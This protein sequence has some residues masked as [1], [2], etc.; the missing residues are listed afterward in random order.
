MFGAAMDFGGLN[1]K[2]LLFEMTGLKEK[3]SQVTGIHTDVENF[4]R[5]G[6]PLIHSCMEDFRGKMTTFVAIW[7]WVRNGLAVHLF[8]F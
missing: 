7:S 3:Y 4:I 2:E 1:M 6:L 5:E 8:C